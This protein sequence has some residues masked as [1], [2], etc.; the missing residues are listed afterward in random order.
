LDPTNAAK[1]G[2]GFPRLS[3]LEVSMGSLPKK[4]PRGVSWGEDLAWGWCRRHDTRPSVAAGW[5]HEQTHSEK[6]RHL[7][8]THWRTNK[9]CRKKDC[10]LRGAPL[11]FRRRSCSGSSS[12]R[13]GP[14]DSMSTAQARKLFCDFTWWDRQACLPQSGLACWSSSGHDSPMLVISWSQAN[15]SVNS[16]ATSPTASTSYGRCSSELLSGLGR[17]DQRGRPR[18]LSPVAD[19][20][21]S[22]VR[23][24]RNSGDRP[25]THGL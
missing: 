1:Y 23:R 24:R 4:T 6:A 17:V 3:R 15:D 21:N 11:W 7:K 5:W 10:L 12:A 14:V 19:S 9:L 22:G 8:R 20:P 13:K 25:R 18:A 2:S 16:L